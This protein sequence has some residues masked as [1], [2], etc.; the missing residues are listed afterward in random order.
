MMAST[1][2]AVL[3]CQLGWIEVKGRRGRLG[4]QLLDDLKNQRVL[5]IERGNIRSHSVEN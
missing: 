4:K 3:I 2:N 5:E 1:V